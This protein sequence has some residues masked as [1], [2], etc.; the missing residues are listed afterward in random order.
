MAQLRR[1]ELLGAAAAGAAAAAVGARTA[2]AA[3]RAR[4]YDVLVVGAGLAG[5][6]AARAVR[7]AGR[8]VLVL[9]ARRRVGGRNLD[10]RLPGGRDVVELG[11]QWAGPGQDRVLALAR[12]LGVATFP[13]YDSGDSVYVRGGARQTYS[14]DIPPAGAVALVQA[15]AL[16]LRLNQ[17]ASTVPADKPWMAPQAATWDEQ[18]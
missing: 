11:G 17:M 10:H 2:P 12:E 5:L 1:R 6:S 7:R 13:T 14:G 18:S 9:E 15:E 16:I 4:S 8:S 3:A